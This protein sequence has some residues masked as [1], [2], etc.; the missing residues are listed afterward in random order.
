MEK[1]SILKIDAAQG[2]ETGIDRKYKE[3]HHEEYGGHIIGY[4]TYLMVWLSL[5]AFTALTVSVA[6]IHFG[7]LTVLIAILIAIVKSS[8]VLYIFMHIKFDDIVFRVFIAVGVLT[9][10]SAIL[11]TY[12]D[13]WFR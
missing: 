2:P 7:S 3:H 13:Y 12:F 1:K 5:V 4:G 10:S 11:G 6:G 9:L 8:L